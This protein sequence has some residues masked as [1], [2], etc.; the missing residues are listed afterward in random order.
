MLIKSAD[1]KSKRLALLEDL[2]KSSLLDARQK[3]WLRVELRN[4]TAGLS[5]CSRPRH[6]GT[7]TGRRLI[8]Q[9]TDLR[10]CREKIGH[11]EGKFCW[12]NARRFG[13]LQ[14]CREHQVLFA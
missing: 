11:P 2:Q 9:K 14:Y 10:H 7:H 8:G 1:D 4:L 13:G 3:E 12:N 5:V 6:P